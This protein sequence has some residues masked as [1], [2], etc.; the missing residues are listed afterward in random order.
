MNRIG[1]LPS[2]CCCM[3]FLLLVE[4]RA[5]LLQVQAFT[6]SSV[7]PSMTFQ[8]LRRS[9]LSQGNIYSTGIEALME[10]PRNRGN[11]ALRMADAAAAVDGED[12][13]MV[14]EDGNSDDGDI[15]KEPN[16]SKRSGFVTALIMAPP[17]LAKLFI[18]L[19]VKFV[20]DVIVFPLLWLYRLV[21]KLKVKLLGASGKIS[22]LNEEE[23]MAATVKVVMGDTWGLRR[24]KFFSFFKNLFRR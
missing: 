21:R 12:G 15:P 24:D 9:T 11:V 6:R 7:P 22:K 18:V 17:L 10:S 14:S 13:N 5:V 4:D 20:T 3:I 19:T 23:D 1:M 16:T 2:L 8:G